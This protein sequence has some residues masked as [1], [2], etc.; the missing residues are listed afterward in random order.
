[1]L[2]Y[3]RRNE[4][5]WSYSPKTER[6]ISMYQE[7]YSDIFTYMAISCHLLLP[8]SPKSLSKDNWHGHYFLLFILNLLIPSFSSCF[9]LSTLFIC[10]LIHSTQSQ[11][12]F[13]Y[14]SF[15]RFPQVFDILSNSPSEVRKVS[16][17]FPDKEKCV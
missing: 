6:T 4:G 13:V 17:V 10:S 8:S 7:K 15:A 16:D 12:K 2:G 9:I 14:V 11:S 1:M 5:N 3:A